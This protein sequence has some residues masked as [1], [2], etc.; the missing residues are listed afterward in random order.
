MTLCYPYHI[1]VLPRG[2]KPLLIIFCDFVVDVCSVLLILTSFFS[3][4]E[5]Q[6]NTGADMSFH[7]CKAW[8]ITDRLL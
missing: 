1:Y 5:S 8:F 3:V 6:R 2:E 7:N 4:R